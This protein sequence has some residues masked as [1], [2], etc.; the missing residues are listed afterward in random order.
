MRFSSWI[1]AAIAFATVTKAVPTSRLDPRDGIEAAKAEVSKRIADV[2]AKKL[3]S[4]EARAAAVKSKQ[5]NGKG[6]C[7]QSC[8]SEN[9][10]FRKEYGDLTREERLDYVKAV[11]CLMELPGRT[12]RSIAPGARSRFDDFTFAH[13]QQTMKIHY[14]G[15]FQPW[16][17]F[18]M[19]SYEKALKEEC[20][21][22]GFHP[23]WD[24]AKYAA[25]PQDSPIFN[26]D[27]TSLGGNGE[28]IGP[29][30]GVN[31]SAST[32]DN[33]L[34]L[35]GGLGGGRVTKGPFANRTILLGPGE[36]LGGNPRPWKR[37]VGPAVN[38][39]WAN[40]T[41]ILDLLRAP[42]IT[43][44]RFVSEGYKDTLKI[45]THGAGHYVIS[46]D[47]GGN[48]FTS[49]NDPAFF[50]HHAQMDRTWALFQEMDPDTR[51]NDLGT[52]PYAHQTMNNNP[53]SNLTTLDEVLDLGYAGGKI[54][55]REV[56]DTTKGPFCY[57]YQ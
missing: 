22:Q 19:W 51:R 50:V 39:R 14:T 40:Y 46:G 37:D 43:A 26:G 41:T 5:K 34:Q 27:D 42:D 28:W 33:P 35:P 45:G 25:A 18:F 38:M 6:P 9:V 17:R 36:D 53:P 23:Y 11:K 4:L 31:L 21:Y 1:A 8:T 44:F 15:N 48:A 32:A 24:W 7:A 47:P 16:H 13:I 56:M 49:P 52:G 10:V 54:T 30:G 20:G 55:I 3:A 57:F 2:T 29:H 12:P